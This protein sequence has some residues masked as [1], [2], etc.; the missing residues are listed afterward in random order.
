MQLRQLPSF[1][2]ISMRRTPPRTTF[3]P[4]TTLFRSACTVKLI[5]PAMVGVPLRNPLVVSSVKPGGSWLPWATDHRYCDVPP[6]AVITDR[7]STRLNSSHVESSY[8]V[9]CLEKKIPSDGASWS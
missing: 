3:F 7:K 6:V 9:F 4:Y 2:I 1:R 5:V 8:A